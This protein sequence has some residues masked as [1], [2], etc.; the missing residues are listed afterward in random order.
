MH[1]KISKAAEGI[2]DSFD[3]FH[4]E[5]KIMTHHAALRFEH[6]DWQAI[7]GDS[8]ERLDHYKKYVTASVEHTRELLSDKINDHATWAE[9]KKKF[10]EL[11]SHR[12]DGPIVETFFNSVLRK[13]FISEGINE[14]I[15][16]IDFDRDVIFVNPDQPIYNSFFLGSDTI[17]IVVRRIMASYNFN[18]SFAD[19]EADVVY[20]TERFT[21]AVRKNFVKISFDRVDMLRS[22][23]YRNKGAYLVGRIIKGN[24]FI[25]VVIPLVN[26]EKGVEVDNVLLTQD[27]ISIVFSFTRSYFF[28]EAENPAELI[29]FLRPLMPQKAVS[30]L[31][32]SIGYNRH[33]KTVLYREIYQHL[34]KTDEKFIVAPGIKGMVM[35]VFTLPTYNMVF[36]VIK[37]VFKPP[38]TVTRKQ[39][40]ETYRFVFMHDRV[41][42]MADPQEF[43]YLKFPVSRFEPEVLDE[44]LSLASEAVYV[45]GDTVVIRQLFTERK[46][47]PLNIYLAEAD[48]EK[49]KNASLDYGNA[50]KELAAANIFPGDLLMKNFGVTRHG[51]VVF[52]DY[53]EIC[54]LTDCNFRNKPEPRS[55]EEEYSSETWFTVAEHDVFPEE[56]RAFMLPSGELRDIFLKYHKD[57]FTVEFWKNMQ[58]KHLTGQVIDFFP[59]QRRKARKEEGVLKLE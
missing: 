25:P 53:D 57:L 21:K 32:S 19:F 5:F 10:S 13:I 56:F 12:Y 26:S 58:H 52:Y 22:V 4:V 38:K 59:Y 27:E 51:R 50:I 40:V 39:V 23:F 8:M 46:M 2:R 11:V 15:E 33:A 28:V 45:E 43:E 42:R 6:R 54:F 36:K 55:H 44:L 37:D 41:G 31:Y 20:M 48:R 18:V 9:L 17:E 29:H 34:E 7:Q 49:A 1:N 3:K 35:S 16:F 47:I 30:E 24:K 14:E